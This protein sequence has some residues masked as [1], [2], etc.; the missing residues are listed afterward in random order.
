MHANIQLLALK[1]I[2]LSHAQTVKLDLAT[3]S[4]ASDGDDEGLYG[5]VAKTPTPQR[6]VSV[7]LLSD[8]YIGLDI[9]VKAV[10]EGSIS[11]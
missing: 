1:R 4:A 5:D 10:D 7:Y 11:K 2:T 8:C 3:S 6:N 9:Q